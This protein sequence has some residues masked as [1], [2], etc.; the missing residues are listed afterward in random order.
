[1]NLTEANK[2]YCGIIIPIFNS[3]KYLDEILEKIGKVQSTLRE[4]VV[5]VLIVDDGSSPPIVT[6]KDSAMTH[7]LIRHEVN[8]GKGAALKTGIKHYLETEKLYA[9]LTLDGDLQ[10]PPELIPKFL[11]SINKNEGDLVIGYRKKI[12]GKMPFHR[13]ISNTLTSY[14]ISFLSKQHIPDSQCGYRV[15]TRRVAEN[16]EINENRFHFESEMIV[17]AALQKFRIAHLPIPTIY[18]NE[19]SAIKNYSDTINFIRLVFR[20]MLER[21][22]ENVRKK[23]K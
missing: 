18:K 21:I 10:H 23:K 17:R 8:K 15:F 11:E 3:S 9:I 4:W 6:I 7:E 5:E 22:K 16:V 1:L 20:L 2:K 12:L 13:I 14:I 19:S